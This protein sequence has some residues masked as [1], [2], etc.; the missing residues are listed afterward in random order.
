[1]NWSASFLIWISNCSDN[2]GG[3]YCPF[4][5]DVTLHFCQ[6]SIF[7]IYICIY[8]FSDFLFCSVDLFV[9]LM[10][11]L[12]CIGS[13]SFIMVWNYIVL[14]L[15]LCSSF[16]FFFVLDFLNFHKDF[17]ISL[18]ISTKSLLEFWLRF[19]WM[20][21]LLWEEVIIMLHL[22]IH[23]HGV[24]VLVSPVRGLFCNPKDCIST[25]IL[26]LWDFPWQEY[27]SG[28]PFPT[29]GN[30]PDPRI[31]LESLASPALEGRCFITATWEAP[32]IPPTIP[33]MNNL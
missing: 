22:L 8:L 10:V 9:Y 26:C 20:Y 13:C 16:S 15:E 24:K 30:L 19:Q 1:M 29:P 25:R 4:S 14:T 3:R 5:V 21:W 17:I 31:Q 28:F 2:T 12:H 18:S 32:L 27:R 11:I 33:K 6:K 23:E 7:H